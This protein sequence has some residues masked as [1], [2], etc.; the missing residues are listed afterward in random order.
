MLASQADV[1]R[2]A[3]CATASSVSVRSG[4]RLD[5]SELRA[6]ATITGDLVIGPTVAVDEINLPALRTVGGKIRVVGNGVLQGLFFP[7]LERAGEID[8][9]GNVAVTTISMPHLQSIHGALRITDNANLELVDLA[10]LSA[11]DRDLVVAA[12]PKLLLLDAPELRHAASV[13]VDAPKLP[14]DIA[15]HLRS[16]TAAR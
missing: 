14:P 7:S 6:L 1:T 3:S 11:I 9:D 8:I 16:V 5:L 4:A 15:T 10:A 13:R 12:D 2:L